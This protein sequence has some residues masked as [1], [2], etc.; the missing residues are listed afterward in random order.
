MHGAFNSTFIGAHLLVDGGLDMITGTLIVLAL[1]FIF[2]G[3]ETAFLSLPAGEAVSKKVQ[4]LKAVFTKTV[5]SMVL[6]NNV[7][8]I[9]GSIYLGARSSQE[10]GPWGQ[11]IYPWIFTALV[12]VFGEIIPKAIGE[13]RPKAVVE[14]AAPLLL[15]LNWF[16]QPLQWCLDFVLRL[17]PKKE[18]VQDEEELVEAA[19]ALDST[20]VSEL[21]MEKLSEGNET[22]SVPASDVAWHTQTI[23]QVAPRLINGEELVVLNE[24]G[25]VGTIDKNS[26][27][28]WLFD[29]Y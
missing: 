11:S 29:H 1:S 12:I 6:G 8:N 14:T 16:F 3:T 23:D 7:V 17:L 26:L 9:A 4:A 18:V 10:L 5:C 24:D 15:F 22:S 20:P 27:L 19:R 13:A 28:K 21:P 2:S 25:I